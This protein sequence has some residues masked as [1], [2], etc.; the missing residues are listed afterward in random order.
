[1]PGIKDPVGCSL[2]ET[3]D[4]KGTFLPRTAEGTGAV[5]GVRGGD[6]GWINGRAH[7]GKILVSGIGD[8]EMDN[9]GLGGGNRRRTAWPSWPRKAHR[10]AQLRDAQDE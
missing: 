2:Q 8:M 7:K 10:A 6:G 3:D 4:G 1:M 9:L 5:Q